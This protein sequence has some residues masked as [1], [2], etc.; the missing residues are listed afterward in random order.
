[1]RPLLFFALVVMLAIVFGAMIAYPVHLLFSSFAD[2]PFHKIISKT[3]LL[4]GLFFSCLY[5]RAY[6]LLS[7]QSLGWHDRQNKFNQHIGLGL[8]AGFVILMLLACNKLFLGLYE[9]DADA[10]LSPSSLVILLIKAMLTGT[11]VSLIEETIFRGALFTG[12]STQTSVCI[13]LFVT[14]L[15]YAAVHY[16]KF[17]ALAPGTDI[18]WLTGVM[19]IPAALFRFSDPVTIDAFLSLF[20]L[21]LLLG[22]MRIQTG[23]IMLCIGFHIGIVAA[24]RIMFYLSDYVRGTQWSFL[25]NKYEHQF[26]HL[27]TAYLLAAVIIYYWA[28]MRRRA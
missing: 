1:M 12:L 24:L 8:I 2:T 7:M 15:L 25:V 9:F 14:S 28:V 17:R 21:G 16:L 6:G 20:V 10:D 5:L 26:G 23:N 27:T 22:M 4:S 3:T 18:G 13:A 11:L 19:M